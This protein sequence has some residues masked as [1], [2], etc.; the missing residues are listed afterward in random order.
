MRRLTLWIGGFIA[1]LV[2]LAVGLSY[3]AEEPLRRRIEA[4]LNN[5]L[6]GYTVRIGHLDLHPIGLS[7]DL[8][9]AYIYQNANPDPPVAFIP[10]FSAS[11]HWRALLRGRLV[12]D[13]EIEKPK[14][15]INL[16]QLRQEAKD[17]VPI[18]E[19]GWQ[20]ALQ[21]VYPLKVNEFIIQKGELTYID[22]GPFK[23]LRLTEVDLIAENIRNV[24]SPAGVYPSPIYLD[25]VVFDKGKVHLKGDADFFAEPTVAVKVDG[26]IQDIALDY[27]KPIAER[28]HL[29]VTKGSPSTEGTVEVAEKVKSISLNKIALNEVEAEYLHKTRAEGPTE[30]IVEKAGETA[31]KHSNEPTL[32]V[33]VKQIDI[34]KSRLGFVNEAAKPA[35][36]VFLSDINGRVE[37]LANQLEQGATHA[38]LQGKFMGSG[39]L[40]LEGRFRPEKAGPDF[41][42]QVKIDETDMRTMNDLFRAYGKFDVVAGVFSFYSELK[43][44]KG[45]VDGY[46]KPLFRDMDVYDSR[47][48]REKSVFKKIYEGLVGGISGLLK[49]TPRQEVA[50]ETR[51]KGDIQNVQTSTWDA[52]VRLIQNALFK[53]I[54]PGFDREVANRSDHRTAAR[55][56]N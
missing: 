8:E 37:N 45:A 24:D 41:D 2:I 48:D 23:P 20:Q 49:N 52:V 26:S 10:T 47:Q 38:T 12:G 9:D 30:K 7:W 19:K 35:Y 1:F 36:R 46:V 4:N 53:A 16:K 18:E 14:L 31:R 15:Y 33:S 39:P 17:K 55:K 43:V 27:F 22:G 28:Y 11:V 56:G 34:V 29:T 21:E 13:F 6:K 54:L 51:V 44:K 42:L 3:F 25:A 40:R 5:R 32:Q 50:T